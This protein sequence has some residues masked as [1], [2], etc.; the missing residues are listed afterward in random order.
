M[1]T[2]AVFEGVRRHLSWVRRKYQLEHSVQNLIVGYRATAYECQFEGCNRLGDY[3]QAYA[4]TFG[5]FT[6]YGE[7]ARINHAAIGRF[8]SIGSFVSLGLW[9]HPLDRNV[10]TH[11]VF[12]SD[13]GQAGGVR[14]VERSLEKEAEPVAIGHDVWIGDY[15]MIRGGVTVGNGA[16]IG[17]GAVVTGDIPAYAVVGGVPAR[18]IRLRF[19]EAEISR[20][21]AM[22]WWNLPDDELRRLLPVFQ[23]LSRLEP[24]A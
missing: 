12:Y 15:A 24:P 19:T 4:S 17:A 8:C 22:A 18:L 3:S 2:K 7:H 6:Y 9:S 23:D 1:I 11:P 20:L 10:S 5:R 21:Q 16:V 13:I 14:W